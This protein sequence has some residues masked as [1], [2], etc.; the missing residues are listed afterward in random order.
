MFD[1]LGHWAITWVDRSKTFKNEYS[2]KED[3]SLVRIHVEG[4]SWRNC[5]DVAD[6]VVKPSD[7]VNY[8][9]AEGWMK[10]SPL[11]YSYSTVYLKKEGTEL[12][13]LAHYTIDKTDRN[14]T[15]HGVV[16]K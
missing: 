1:V 6:A 4:C 12:R 13:L 16:G 8:P 7:N 10:A 3:A 2:I 5:K 14:I 15:G 9:S 11:H